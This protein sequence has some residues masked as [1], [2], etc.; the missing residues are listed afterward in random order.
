[1]TSPA[2]T[3]REPGARESKLCWHRKVITLKLYEVAHVVDLDPIPQPEDEPGP[4]ELR[5]EVLKDRSV[6]GQYFARVLRREPRGPR[7][8]ADDDETSQP[9]VFV[10]D[11]SQDWARMRGDAIEDVLRAVLQRIENIYQ[12]H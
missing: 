3:Q 1:M 6:P 7:H 8:Q 9:T 11:H 5:V 10:E 12:Q 2:A 4:V